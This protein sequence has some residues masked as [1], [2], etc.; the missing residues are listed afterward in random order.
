MTILS[1]IFKIHLIL[2]IDHYILTISS[3]FNNITK[4]SS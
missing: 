3:Q 1:N 4:K 2:R